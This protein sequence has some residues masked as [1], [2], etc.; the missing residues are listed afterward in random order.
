MSA[1]GANRISSNQGIFT[2]VF[3]STPRIDAL[4]EDGLR[5]EFAYA[6]PLCEPSRV[7]LM[8]GMNNDRNFI[9]AKA[10]HDSHVTI[11]DVFQRAGYVTGITGKWKQSRG[12][13]EFP[14]KSMSL[15]LAGMNFIVLM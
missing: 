9:Q 13:K 14:G 3:V 12:T 7:A 4:G 10:L 2:N 6:Y 11:G 5:C 15:N 1:Y 8:T